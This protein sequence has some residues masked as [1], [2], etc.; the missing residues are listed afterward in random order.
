MKSVGSLVQLHRWRQM[1]GRQ[2]LPSHTC[3]HIYPSFL[4]LPSSTILPLPPSPHLLPSVPH[5]LRTKLDLDLEARQQE[6]E[7]EVKGKGDSLKEDIKNFNKMIVS[8][9]DRVN[10]AREELEEQRAKAGLSCDPRVD[11]VTAILCPDQTQA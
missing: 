4:L 3:I 7:E 8:A 2:L 6:L 10:E 9:L 1:N 5:Y 11:L